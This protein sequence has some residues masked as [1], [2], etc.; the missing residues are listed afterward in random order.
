MSNIYYLD[1]FRSSAEAAAVAPGPIDRLAS[2]KKSLDEALAL[3]ATLRA[4]KAA[5]ELKEQPLASVVP[6]L[7]AATPIVIYFVSYG[8]NAWHSTWIA[9]YQRNSLQS[10]YLEASH[11]IGS[12]MKQGTAF[13]MMIT[14]GWH[15]QFSSNAFLICD[16]NTFQPFSR[17]LDA[18]F[19]VPGISEERAL[20]LLN[21]TS[22]LWQGRAPI[23]DSII[24]QETKR[25][26]GEFVSWEEADEER[27]TVD[28]LWSRRTKETQQIANNP[29][30]DRIYD[31]Q[32]PSNYGRYF[33]NI[34]KETPADFCFTPCSKGGP[35]E[36][37]CDRFRA[38][39]AAQGVAAP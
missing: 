34:R 2:L 16:I 21:P 9:K 31:P 14:P 27:S 23:H 22:S 11:F 1:D 35:T 10:S 32:K 39:V 24:I 30:R 33:R 18:A 17:L 4:A 5:R 36:Y 37:D 15:L 19:T 13:K 26:A 6:T 28:W 38:L 20:M 25:P 29:Q 12:K 3:S 8:R 7:Q